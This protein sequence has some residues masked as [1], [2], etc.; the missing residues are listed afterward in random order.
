MRD[1]AFPRGIRF[2]T[3]HRAAFPVALGP[4]D[5]RHVNLRLKAPANARPGDCLLADLV[6]RDADRRAIGGISVQINIQEGKRGES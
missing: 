4:G 1:Q 2:D 3:G 6:Q 5:R